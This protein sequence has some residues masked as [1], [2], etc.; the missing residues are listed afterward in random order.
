MALIAYAAGGFLLSLAYYDG[1]FLLIVM[2][3]CA[4]R[5]LREAE[6]RVPARRGL[7]DETPPKPREM[8]R[9][10]RPQPLRA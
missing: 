9:R 10:R 2:V 8:R 7:P 1:Y 3:V 4:D 5:L 6:G